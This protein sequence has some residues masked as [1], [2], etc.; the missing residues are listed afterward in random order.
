M[1][2]RNCPECG[3]ESDEW[4][5]IKKCSVCGHSELRMLS[6]RVESDKIITFGRLKT[7][8]NN[9]W[10]KPHLGEDYKFWD[11]NYQMIFEPSEGEWKLK[12][13]DAALNATLIDGKKLVGEVILTNGMKIAVGKEATDDMPEII[14]SPMQV[15]L[16]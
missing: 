16:E 5:D 6:L 7:I 12:A 3:V 9:A 8:A 13:N 4:A 2:N 14:K 11:K 10:I 1:H 15:I